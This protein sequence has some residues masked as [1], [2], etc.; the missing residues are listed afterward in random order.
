MD[1]E[2]LNSALDRRALV[3]KA[4]FEYEL[5]FLE[6]YNFQFEPG[7]LKKHREPAWRR[8]NISFTYVDFF[9]DETFSLSVLFHESPYMVHRKPLEVTY[10]LLGGRG[11]FLNYGW[12]THSSETELFAQLERIRGML[13]YLLDLEDFQTAL[14]KATILASNLNLAATERTMR[15]LV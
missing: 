3:I 12:Q 5:G 15:G 4:F 13:D 9:Q 8:G 10:W 1:S 6:A 7:S 11:Y 14:E 2:A